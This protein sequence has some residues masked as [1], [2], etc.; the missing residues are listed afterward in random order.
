MT[1]VPVKGQVS[2]IEHQIRTLVTKYIMPPNALIL[3]ISPANADLAISDAL[4]LAR[5]VDPAGD[6]TIGVITKIDLMDAGTDA[7]EYLQGSVYP[8]KLGYFGCKCRSQLQIE[9]KVPISEALVAEAD[10][11]YRH[12]VYSAQSSKMGIPYLTRQLNK[13]L[14]SHIQRCIPNLS[15]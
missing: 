11:F 4:Q 13:I 2:D 9:Q 8:L 10:F 15:K 7:L 6:R 14:V 1:K 12:P 3:A 5:Q